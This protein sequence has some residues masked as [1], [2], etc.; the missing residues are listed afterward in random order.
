MM[1]DDYVPNP[2][3]PT[4]DELAARVTR[5]EKGEEY[6]D[7]FMRAV[8]AFLQMQFPDKLGDLTLPDWH[9]GVIQ[10]IHE[11]RALDDARTRLQLAGYTVWEPSTAPGELIIDRDTGMPTSTAYPKPNTGFER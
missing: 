11:K 4:I 9:V 8:N 7:Q 5:L 10:A 1:A 6:G 3:P 2:A